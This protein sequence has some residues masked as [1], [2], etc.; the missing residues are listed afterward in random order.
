MHFSHPITMYWTEWSLEECDLKTLANTPLRDL[1]SS[2]RNYLWHARE[3]SQ[4]RCRKLLDEKCKEGGNQPWHYAMHV[5]REEG[6]FDLW[7]LTTEDNDFARA[8]HHLLEDSGMLDV[9]DDYIRRYQ[10]RSEMERM[11]TDTG[12]EG[13][14][15]QE[16]DDLSRRGRKKPNKRQRQRQKLQRR[17]QQL[18]E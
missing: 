14:T 16:T 18:A 4:Q 10:R 15:N 7:N 6:L 8:L 1:S 9:F 17:V 11:G 13:S 3:Q 12:G 5:F 2:E